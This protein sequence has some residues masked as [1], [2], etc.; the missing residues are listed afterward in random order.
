MKDMEERQQTGIGDKTNI[1][2]NPKLLMKAL[3][4]LQTGNS[5][6]MEGGGGGA[7]IYIYPWACP[8]SLVLYKEPLGEPEEG[9]RLPEVLP[10]HQARRED[11]GSAIQLQVKLSILIYLSFS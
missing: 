5:F 9:A 7:K 3:N 6:F 10:S 8:H 4:C 1:S 2:R 11:P